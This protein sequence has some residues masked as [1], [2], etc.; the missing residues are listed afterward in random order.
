MRCYV[1]FSQIWSHNYTKFEK[2]LCQPFELVHAYL[3][4]L[5]L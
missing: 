3:N 5:N 1:W 4:H 2:K